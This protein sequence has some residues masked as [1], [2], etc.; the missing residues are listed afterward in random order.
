[1]LGT[2]GPQRNR[3]MTRALTPAL[4]AGLDKLRENP[5]NGEF[6]HPRWHASSA[7]PVMLWQVKVA[8]PSSSTLTSF[9]PDDG[10]Q[11][12]PVLAFITY[13]T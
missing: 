5:H 2:H 11:A 4:N 3:W 7:R 13:V 6:A 1:M 12:S 9:K 10:A 8:N